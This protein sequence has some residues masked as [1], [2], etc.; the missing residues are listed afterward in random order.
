[1]TVRTNQQPASV[2]SIFGRIAGSSDS[3]WSGVAQPGTAVGPRRRLFPGTDDL[4]DDGRGHQGNSP[5]RLFLIR[6]DE[7]KQ[8]QGPEGGGNH[9]ETAKA[10]RA[11]AVGHLP[12]AQAAERQ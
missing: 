5:V 12:P 2:S 8:H 11:M 6:P 3:G 4:D 7:A 10:M 9:R 1:M